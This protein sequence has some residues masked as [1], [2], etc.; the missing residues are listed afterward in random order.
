[1]TGARAAFEIEGAGV[2][3]RI[4]LTPK[5]GRDALGGRVELA[6]GDEALAARVAAPPVEG[7]ANKALI[8]L[9]A[10]SFGVPKS[11]VE[12]ASGETS[13]LKTLRIAGDPMALAAKARELLA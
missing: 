8:K 2:S 6:D 4:R 11:S 9:V 3:V 1:V 7:A 13:R 10:K 12:I 5:G